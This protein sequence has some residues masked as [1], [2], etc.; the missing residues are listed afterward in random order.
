MIENE[1]RIPL[2]KMV[3]FVVRSV[4][5][6]DGCSEVSLTSLCEMNGK[7]LK[8]IWSMFGVSKKKIS[9]QI[10]SKTKK[11]W[12]DGIIIFSPLTTASPFNIRC[13]AIHK[14]RSHFSEYLFMMAPQR[15]QNSIFTNIRYENWMK[16][17]CWCFQ[18][19]YP[20]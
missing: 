2:D 17:I 6:S 14:R 16:W 20:Y 15:Q 3:D 9:R 1:W 4:G 12:C 10:Y 13:T 5:R 18:T 8:V 19:R 11:N 7:V